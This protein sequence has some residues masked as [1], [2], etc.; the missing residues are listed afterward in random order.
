MSRLLEMDSGFEKIR[1]KIGLEIFSDGGGIVNAT[2]AGSL[3]RTCRLTLRIEPGGDAKAGARFQFSNWSTDV[4][5]LMPGAVYGGNRFP[6]FASPYP[7]LL[8][9]RSPDDPDKSLQVSDIP[10]LL[11][12][13]GES[14]LRQT[15]A[16]PA[17]PAV[18][19]FF[20]VQ[21]TAFWVLTAPTCASG[22][23][24][25]ELKE[26]PDRSAATLRILAAPLT[27][28]PVEAGILV[29]WDD[30]ESVQG[31]FDSLTRLRASMTAPPQRDAILPF[32]A[33]WNVLEEKQNR[34]NWMDGYFAVGTDP[35]RKT[36]ASQNWQMGWTGGMLTAHAL[37]L[38]GSDLSRQ[39]ALRNFDFVFPDGQAPSGF[40][41]GMGDGR[42]W[43]GDH[44][45]DPK[46]PWH[47]VRKS[48]DGLY[49]M[50]GSL[51]HLRG[52]EDKQLIKPGWSA[53]L[54]K[55]ADAFVKLWDENHQFG[56]FVDHNTGKILVANSTSG[57]L[58]PAALVRAA[59]YFPEA[60]A[61]YLRVAVESAAHFT[62]NDLRR[63]ITSGGPGDAAQCPDSESLAG[64]LESLMCV[65][66]ATGDARWLQ[67]A[68][69]AA[70]Q[71]SS[72]VVPYDFQFPKE[73]TFE[74]LGMRTCGTVLANAQ[75]KHSAPGLCTHSGVALYSLYLATG[76]A[77]FMDLLR[78]IAHA[79]PQF[80]SRP[81]RLIPFKI[82]Y[83]QPDDPA[84][85]WLNPGW[86]NERVNM[87]RW[88]EAE[89]PG[90]VFYCSCW[91]E[92]SLMLSVAELPGVYARLDTR[93]IWCLDHVEA[94]WGGE[95]SLIV[96]NPTGFPAQV[97]VVVE[98]TPASKCRRSET[99]AI[100]PGNSVSVARPEERGF[101][102][103]HLSRREALR[104]GLGTIAVAALAGSWV[105]RAIAK[106]P[107]G[108]TSKSDDK[109]SVES[110]VHL[111]PQGDDKSTGS[112]E[113]P[114]AT[115]ARAIELARQAKEARRIVVHGGE[116][117][118]TAVTL[119]ALDSGL[120]IEAAP[121]GKP[122]FYGGRRVTGWRQ[123]G[124]LW[125]TDLPDVNGCSWDFRHLLVN[126]R[127][128]GRARF[129]ESGA[130]PHESVFPVR[131]MTST[132]G[133]WERK[134]T[135][136]ELTTL[137]F[138]P[139]VLP[140]SLEIANAELTIYH[141]WD[142][143]LVG[144]ASIDRVNGIIR[145]STPAGHPPGAFGDS[146][147][148]AHTFVVWNTREGLTKPGQ[149]FLDRPT[150]RLFYWPM[151]GEEPA[152]AQV[153]APTG[154]VI[155]R[156]AG[157][158][159]QPVRDLVFY[160]LAFASTN[161][162]MMA[163]GFGAN[164]FEGAIHGEH[165]ADIRMQDLEFFGTGGWAAKLLNVS[166]L[167]WSRCVIRNAGAGGLAVAGGPGEITDTL[168]H[169][170]GLSYPSAMAV[171]CN[172]RDWLVAHN[173][174]H[175]TPYSAIAG[176][177]TNLR[178]ESNL[179]HHIMQV[180]TDGAAIYLFGGKKCV[181]RGNHAHNILG[182]QAHAY[183]L[184]EQSEESVVEGNLAVDVPWPLHMHMARHCIIRGNVCV[185]AGDLEMS[186]MNCDGF[187]VERNILS[188]AGELRVQV[189]Y[190]GVAELLRNVFWSGAGCVNWRMTD[191]L[192]SLERNPGPV[193]I[194]PQTEQTLLANPKVECSPEG[195]VRFGDDA[196]TLSLPPLDVRAAGRRPA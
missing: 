68:R 7:P 92:V 30:C 26:N 48:A 101:H 135:G 54:K 83:C 44:F 4:Y 114:V 115:L 36:H 113:R 140:D 119:T 145:F 171:N 186:L 16:D 19:F 172:G 75:N 123:E 122:V 31:L 183:Y 179:L 177:G 100:A 178:M 8:A 55:C 84:Q 188:A 69:D 70:I 134:P 184:D 170:V 49:F 152:S 77:F 128:A 76:D 72:W 50:L 149:W 35:V 158:Q 141:S 109:R 42:E 79:L 137:K 1:A 127:S 66:S 117:F 60:S 133:G 164:V 82:P 81:D 95:G 168:I 90:E 67:A 85:T 12:G 112:L 2:G 47:L 51:L 155:L 130:L 176:S 41:Y 87:S 159:E 86:M 136:D 106:T 98:Q 105:D 53:G 102:E 181:L 46:A 78:D 28:G 196:L 147:Q 14:L 6:G 131:W 40:F 173:E 157:T 23:I 80:L 71:L 96:R 93:E 5:V 61:K 165:L 91:P 22:L 160:G 62:D 52:T 10:R 58:V 182:Q 39:R 17:V 192:P 57:A 89:Y 107:T 25:Y 190:T 73:S 97:D 194:F 18:G 64:L 143:S 65:Y 191:R 180:L 24:E 138:H 104:R 129:P 148:A 154:P 162:P 124:E 139:G 32:S 150:G 116:Y 27:D 163:G 43:M 37:I 144:V 187:V 156:L 59:E 33:A 38:R 94:S 174:I 99:L 15:S 118:E 45:R 167:K 74:R 195:L 103:L 169:D 121:G 29:A 125:V 146:K 110:T 111:S 108:S 63:G 34:E 132:K 9:L 88:G 161:T 13:P 175:H 151:P 193:P 126:G 120:E 166:G 21:K 153:I 3:A 20:P 142:E 185:N 189:S 11:A 56:Q